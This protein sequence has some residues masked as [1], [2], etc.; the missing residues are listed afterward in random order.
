MCVGCKVLKIAGYV[1]GVVPSLVHLV[2]CRVLEL[3]GV[4]VSGLHT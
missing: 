3:G 1:F 2:W 4:L